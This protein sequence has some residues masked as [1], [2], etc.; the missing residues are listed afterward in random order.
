MSL[1]SFIWRKETPLARRIH[2]GLKRAAR[3]GVP[4]IPGVHHLLLA[5]RRFWRGPWV[6]IA[7]KLYHEPLL[8]LCC[9]SVGGG[10]LLYEDMPKIF[11]N[12]EIALGE[13]VSMSGKNVW[14]GA[15]SV[16]VRKHLT[17]GDHS[18]L[19]HGVEFIV[20]TRIDVG[21]HVMVANRAIFN[22]YDGHPLDPLARARFEPP[23][24]DGQG[25][26]VIG[27]YAWIG[28]NAMVLKNVTIGRGAVIAAGSIVTES[29]PELAVVAGVPARV[30][31][32]LPKPAEW[33]D[34]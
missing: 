25:P 15:G 6:W 3:M 29:V 4:V 8:K 19:G 11:G 2:A 1:R 24:P 22:G 34:G 14:I 26:I 5:N 27:D 12:I 7:S 13:R 20:G 31:K 33:Q 23:G 18:Y 17:V 30:L 21:K 10:L 32:I 16:A 9:K 28:T